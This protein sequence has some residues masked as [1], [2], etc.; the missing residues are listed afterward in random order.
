V[1]GYGRSTRPKEMDEAAD[2]HAPLVRTNLAARDID[3]VVKWIGERKHVRGVAILGWATGGQWAAYYASVHPERVTALITLNSLYGGSSVHASLGHGSDS[4]DPSHPGEFHV[5]SCGAYRLND[6]A[7]LF[8]AWDRSIPD[9]DKLSWRDPAVARA[10]AAEAM[11]SD[12]TSGRRTPASFRSPCGAL[13]DSFYLAIG[14]KLWD[15]G[16]ITAP[17]L[18]LRSQRDFWSR[19]ED[20]EAFQ[21]DLLHAGHVKVVTVPNADHFVHLERGARGRDLV[22]KEVR[23]FLQ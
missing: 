21:K 16:K 23:Q 8:R 13:E 7:S 1:R 6:E 15:A 11:A 17:V 2:A 9:A 10:Y 4:E 3:A 18:I 12:P 5:K 19:A 22:L 20:A 14:K